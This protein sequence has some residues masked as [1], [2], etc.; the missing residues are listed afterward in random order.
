MKM[1]GRKLAGAT[2]FVGTYLKALALVVVFLG[3]T[4]LPATK[5][6]GTGTALIDGDPGKQLNDKTP[7][8]NNLFT[9]YWRPIDGVYD[10]TDEQQDNEWG[11][12]FDENYDGE[13]D[14]D[15]CACVNGTDFYGTSFLSDKGAILLGS[16]DPDNEITI[17]LKHGH[18]L[19]DL[20]FKGD[21]EACVDAYP[22][23]NMDLTLQQPTPDVVECY[24]KTRTCG[25]CFQCWG[26]VI[27]GS[28]GEIKLFLPGEVMGI[29]RLED[30]GTHGPCSLLQKYES[31]GAIP[32]GSDGWAQEG[33]FARIHLTAQGGNLS[34]NRVEVHFKEVVFSVCG[35]NNNDEEWRCVGPYPEREP[36]SPWIRRA[37]NEVLWQGTL[38]A[39][40]GR[41]LYTTTD[42][43]LYDGA[44]EVRSTGRVTVQTTTMTDGYRDLNQNGL[45]DPGDDWD[46]QDWD[47]PAHGIDTMWFTTELSCDAVW[48]FYGTEF[49]GFV[50]RDLFI[51]S[52]E[53]DNH[54]TIRDMT[55]KSLTMDSDGDGILD[56]DGRG[57]TPTHGAIPI[58]GM[59]VPYKGSYYPIDR[60]RYNGDDSFDI[61]LDAWENWAHVPNFINYAYGE[62][63]GG[64]STNGNMYGEFFRGA[65]WNGYYCGE[66]FNDPEYYGE[67]YDENVL[68]WKNVPKTIE[69]LK[70]DR[71]HNYID[72]NNFESDWVHIKADRPVTLYGGIWDNNHHT[73]CYGQLGMRYYI[74]VQ[75]AITISPV[76][77]TAHV[78]IRWDDTP[79]ENAY[80]TIEKGKQFT[81]KT[82]RTQSHSHNNVANVRWVRVIS[83]APIKV[84]MWTANDDNAFDGTTVASFKHG[85]DYYPA[86]NRWTVP[87][88]H[89]AIIYI[90][91]LEDDTTVGWTGDW[92]EGQTK[93]CKMRAYETYR[94]VYDENECYN[95]MG[96]DDVCMD[97]RDEMFAT[98]RVM[99]ISASRDVLVRV[100]YAS[101]YSC[102]PQDVDLILSNAPTFSTANSQGPWMLPSVMAGVLAIDIGV[103]AAG[104]TGLMAAQWPRLF[105]K[106]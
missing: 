52:Y 48:S 98:V 104:G 35:D 27:K 33:D 67:V 95:D 97:N 69:V 3:L 87:I 81:T 28:A 105:K 2:G 102:E 61:V 68:G 70:S 54:I 37:Q 4:M 94:V 71:V 49:F 40:Q 57:G 60:D 18:R 51:A 62:D 32:A 31:Y 83:D 99:H 11:L 91:A 17:T 45:A 72:C 100:E 43:A 8:V 10:Q 106:R 96:E 103:V 82:W 64:Y 15:N 13:Q 78:D 6:T 84:D 101:D 16:Y 77:R 41:I 44:V 21:E 85:N 73:Q 65:P 56:N 14:E 1:S 66:F 58:Q 46:G 20:F 88:H 53:D 89:C 30:D 47:Q 55:A 59:K 76:D 90:T 34:Q 50:H 9:F 29:E 24:W 12:V 38:G 75:R 63:D 23:C 22:Y 93:G 86:D 74:P 92:L 80:V 42:L 36:F 79:Q 19:T 39:L 5:I 25:D 7:F 26:S